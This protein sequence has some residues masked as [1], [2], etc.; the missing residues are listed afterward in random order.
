MR[1]MRPVLGDGLVIVSSLSKSY[2]MTGWR[3]GYAL[4]PRDLIRA[5]ATVQA[6]DASQAPTLSQCAGLAALSGTQEPLAVMLA[7]YARRRAF[8]IPALRR[9][10]GLVC[11]EP[12]GAFYAF[13]RVTGLYR[14]LGVSSSAELAARLVRDAGVVTVAGE[15]F[16]APGY[17]RISYAA[18]LPQIE[19][20]VARIA[21]L[22][23]QRA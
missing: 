22:V 16:G 21:G 18:S 5:A 6:H 17:I 10:E 23:A 14:S 1:A 9:I 15:G 20:G 12:H 19:Q 4:G 7:E 2:A 13:P 3:L 11:T 8:L